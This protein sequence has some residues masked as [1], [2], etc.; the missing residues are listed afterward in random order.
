MIETEI[1]FISWSDSIAPHGLLIADWIYVLRIAALLPGSH[2]SRS[3]EARERAGDSGNARRSH[4]PQ[5]DWRVQSVRG[6]PIR[7]RRPST[8]TLSP[9]QIAETSRLAAGRSFSL[10]ASPA[11]ALARSP[12]NLAL[13]AMTVPSE[14]FRPRDHVGRL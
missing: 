9:R 10:T 13:R 8:R 7:A 5:S 4:C 6:E 1:V 3:P 14:S 11:T 2:P 12:T